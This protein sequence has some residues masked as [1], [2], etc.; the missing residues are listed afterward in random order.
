MLIM[1][2]HR[3]FSSWTAV[4]SHGAHECLSFPKKDIQDHQNSERET[5]SLAD[6]MSSGN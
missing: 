6:S 2:M 3:L 5:K 4:S 1:I